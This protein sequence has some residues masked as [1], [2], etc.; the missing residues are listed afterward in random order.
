MPYKFLEHTADIG[1]EITA[2]DLK[3]AFIEAIYGLLDL[4]FK[5]SFIDVDCEKSFESLEISSNDLESLLVD[6]LNEILFLIDSKKII[7]V[8]LEITEMSNNS[9]KIIYKPL[10]LDL[11]ETPMHLYVKAV[12]YHQLEIIQSKESTTIRFYL[13]I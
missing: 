12:T 13:D 11:S 3:Q 6:T 2:T 9:L 5:K 8:K 4:I 10:E 1:I 7:P